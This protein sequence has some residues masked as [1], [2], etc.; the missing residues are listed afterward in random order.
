MCPLNCISLKCILHP[1]LLELQKRKFSVCI[2]YHLQLC[3]LMFHKQS[4]MRNKLETNWLF[5]CNL[6]HCHTDLTLSKEECSLKEH[7]EKNVFVQK[8]K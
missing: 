2:L 6:F 7:S 1:K 3:K 5:I 8:P 4:Q